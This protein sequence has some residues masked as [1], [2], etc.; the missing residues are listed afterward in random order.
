MTMHLAS[1]LPAGVGTDRARRLRQNSRLSVS[2]D[3]T[4]FAACYPSQLDPKASIF[5]HS[6]G[7]QE[8]VLPLTDPRVHRVG[9]SDVLLSGQHSDLPPNSERRFFLV[10]PDGKMFAW[11]KGWVTRTQRREKAPLF[12]Q[13]HYGVL[14]NGVRTEFYLDSSGY[15]EVGN[16]FFEELLG[17]SRVNLVENSPDGQSIIMLVWPPQ[18]PRDDPELLN[19]QRMILV[20]SSDPEI[21]QV[22]PAALASW[23]SDQL[24]VET[25]FKGRFRLIKTFWSPGGD[26]SIFIEVTR[27]QGWI[28]HRQL[29]VT[30]DR[31]EIEIDNGFRVKD[32]VLRSGGQLAAALIR[33]KDDSESRVLDSSGHPI[34]TAPDVWNLSP[35]DNGR[36]YRY[37]VI[38]S[39]EVRLVSVK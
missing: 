36:G 5:F 14:W 37:N 11:S 34:I 4:V 2:P 6:R 18:P 26:P 29:L 25:I 35:T 8:A 7:K 16:E 15:W 10:T 21:G 24:G 13:S 31:G 12:R 30:P 22:T 9:D 33:A 23:T 20:R 28:E 1:P 19:Y 3:G 27:D 17:E 39:G 38:E 32:V